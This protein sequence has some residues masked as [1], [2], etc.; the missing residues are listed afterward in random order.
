M[1]SGLA[2]KFNIDAREIA[3]FV[4]QHWKEVELWQIPSLPDESTAL[5]ELADF[6]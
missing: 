6:N 2:E 4:K 1:G 3:D 5:S